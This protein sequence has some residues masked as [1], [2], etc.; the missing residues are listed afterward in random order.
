MVVGKCTPENV[1]HANARSI[2]L[3]VVCTVPSMVPP[4]PVRAVL[5]RCPL[6]GA[7]AGIKAAVDLPPGQRHD[8]KIV[9]A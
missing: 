8:H 5:M 3:Y 9:L 6:S 1:L 4:R 7:F 2:P